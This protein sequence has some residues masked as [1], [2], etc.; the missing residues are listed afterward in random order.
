MPVI[1]GV[2]TGGL[3]ILSYK[4]EWNQGGS[5]NTFLPLIG[6]LVDNLLTSYTETSLT[7]GTMYKFRYTVLNDDDWSEYSDVL[8]TYAAIVPTQLTAP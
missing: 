8:T 1:T 5:G 4:L 3:P 2:R 7:T 6:D